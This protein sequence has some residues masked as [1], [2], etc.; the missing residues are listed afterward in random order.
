MGYKLRKAK[1]K[2]AES[3]INRKSTAANSSG[4]RAAAPIS[5]NVDDHI[6]LVG[7]DVSR[8]QRTQGETAR[9]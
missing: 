1:A 6:G 7:V 8:D 2:E 5:E 9:S 4:P 3:N